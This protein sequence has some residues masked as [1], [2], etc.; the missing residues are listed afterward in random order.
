MLRGEGIRAREKGF[1]LEGLSQRCPCSL[2]TFRDRQRGSQVLSGCVEDKGMWEEAGCGTARAFLHSAVGSS[3]RNRDG[4]GRWG[5]GRA[6][7][8]KP[9][10]VKPR[11]LIKP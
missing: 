8:P 3:R 11:P 7:D 1:R 5:S 2:P 9:Q 10:T 6:A 4:D